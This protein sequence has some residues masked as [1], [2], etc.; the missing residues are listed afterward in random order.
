MKLDTFNGKVAVMGLAFKAN[1]DDMR[2]SPSIEI[3]RKLALANPTV[4]FLAVEPHV[5]SA[6]KKLDGISNLVLTPMDEALE[7]ANVVTLLVD[8]DQ[9]KSVP[10]TTLAGKEVIDTRGLWR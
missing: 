10:A 8:H 1:I 5:E 9:F 3:A 6:P 2:E 7:V 4:E